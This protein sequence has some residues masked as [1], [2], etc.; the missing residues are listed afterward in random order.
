[1]EVEEFQEMQNLEES[2]DASHTKNLD[3]YHMKYH[4]TQGG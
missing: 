2:G 3:F 1:M 4:G